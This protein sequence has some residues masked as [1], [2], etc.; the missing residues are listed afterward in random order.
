MAFLRSYS[1]MAKQLSGEGL[2]PYA[3]VD[4]FDWTDVCKKYNIS[5]Y[6]TLRV[7][8]KGKQPV[9]YKGLLDGVAVTSAAK[10]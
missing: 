1:E 8:R 5:S 6:P 4:C 7:Y 3:R 9:E 10:M 2:Q